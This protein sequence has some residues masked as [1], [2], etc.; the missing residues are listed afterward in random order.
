MSAPALWHPEAAAPNSTLYTC[1]QILGLYNT[2][3]L[4]IL[5][6]ESAAEHEDPKPVYSYTAAANVKR[7]G[8]KKEKWVTAA[9]KGADDKSPRW[10]HVLLIGGILIGFEA[11]DRKGLPSWLR[12]KLESALVTAANLALEEQEVARQRGQYVDPVSG[13]SVALALNHAFPLLSDFERL[14]VNYDLLL[15]VLVDATL[16]SNEG[17][18]AGYFLGAIDND[19]KPAAA[20]VKFM[21]SARSES[22]S[23]VREI[24]A[25]PLISSLGP[26]SRLVA[27]SVENVQNPALVLGMM[28]RLV[29]FTRTIMVQWR[30]NKLSEIDSSEEGE[31]LEQESLKVTVP[32]LWQLLRT[33]MFAC[34]IILRAV[35]GR[36]LSDGVLAAGRH[37]PVIATQSLQVL[38]NLFFISWRFG[39][40]SASQY[41]FVNLTALDILSQYPLAAE[42]FIKSIT[43][44]H[45]N[46]NIDQTE[47]ISSSTIPAHPLDRTLD[48][49][50]LNTSEHLTL[51]LSPATNETSLLSSS[52][53]YLTTSIHNRNL[54]DLF[55]SAHSVTLAVLASPQSATTGL[56][57]K[58]LPFYI[59]ALFNA[60]PGS[61][62]PRQ[63]RMAFTS[64]IRLV[65]PP[66]TLSVSD[67]LLPDILLELVRDRATN[68]TAQSQTSTLALPQTEA[69]AASST[70][71]SAPPVSEQTALILTLIDA[72][73][74]L[75]PHET[76]PVWLSLA[77]H[78]I[79]QIKDYNGDGSGAVMRRVCQERFWEVVSGQEMDVERAAVCVAWWGTRGGREMVL[80]GEDGGTAQENPEYLMSGGLGA[81]SKL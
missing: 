53:P 4:T 55:E 14:Q 9:V 2:A 68:P 26:L 7:D 63:F 18:R 76:L 61:I 1:R 60:F 19:V 73:P 77:A 48:L 59:T 35:L 42:S 8:L 11:S 24:S 21:W 30:Q 27:H 13:Y 58:I 74:S 3:A 46:G 54:T 32:V 43:P 39:Q 36:V 45:H 5:Q 33:S 37:S 34:V 10:R 31:F 79:H 38:R 78:A 44:S 49:F 71:T 29:E 12:S 50:F 28:E 69:E 41:T 64:V 23:R 17:L 80:Y 20:G 25:S 67:P 47:S 65:S 81:Q 70:E 56:T 75:A 15:P 16:F 40:N 6:R 72:L 66:S 57:T 52:F 51:T 22:Y 62:S